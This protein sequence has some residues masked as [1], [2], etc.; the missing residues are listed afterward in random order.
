MSIN[1]NHP[2]ELCEVIGVYLDHAG[3]P[4]RRPK[5]RHLDLAAKVIFSFHI[6]FQLDW[7]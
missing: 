4:K 1:V 5:E 3:V 7:T 2:V 6:I